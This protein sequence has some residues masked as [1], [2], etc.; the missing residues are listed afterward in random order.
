MKKAILVCKSF[1]ARRCLCFYEFAF[2]ET[3]FFVC[4]VDCSGITRDN[5][6]TFE[7]GIDRVFGEL[8]RCGWQFV[9]DI[10]KTVSESDSDKEAFDA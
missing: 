6:Y 2:P 1:H 4:P 7:K 9:D 10:K 3:E 5:W 8:Y